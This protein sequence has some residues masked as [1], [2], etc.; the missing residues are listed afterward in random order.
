MTE[1]QAFS[2]CSANA[3]NKYICQHLDEKTLDLCIDL[4]MLCKKF[5]KEEIIPESTV[6]MHDGTLISFSTKNGVLL[7]SAKRL[8]LNK[9]H[10]KE[11]FEA[12]K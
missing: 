7:T 11:D 10:K 1:Q 3:T 9:Q 6:L 2:I 12:T 4:D 8:K 5:G